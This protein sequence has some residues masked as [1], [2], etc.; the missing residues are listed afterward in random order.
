MKAKAFQTRR[1]QFEHLGRQHYQRLKDRLEPE[2]IGK[3]VAVEVESGEYFLGNT[4]VEAI[5]N[6]EA[7]YPEE[8]LYIA[9]IG[10]RAVYVKR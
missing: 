3:I 5:K 4:V 2:H 8:L 9:R 10:Y 1:A 7:K 6:A